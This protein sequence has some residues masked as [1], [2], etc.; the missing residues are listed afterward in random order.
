MANC[1]SQQLSSSSSSSKAR[2]S[3]RLSVRNSI[4][5]TPG[6]A[7]Q[8]SVRRASNRIDPNLDFPDLDLVDWG[9]F[10]EDSDDDAAQN[11]TNVAHEGFGNHN[12]ATGQTPNVV[13]TGHAPIKFY[14][15]PNV[16]VPG[17]PHVSFPPANR[18][19]GP[20]VGLPMGF[21]QEKAPFVI[22]GKTV[23]LSQEQVDALSAVAGLAPQPLLTDGKR[24]SVPKSPGIRKRNS[25]F[26]PQAAYSDPFAGSEHIDPQDLQFGVFSNI[27][28]TP[29]PEPTAYPEGYADARQLL[30]QSPYYQS[31][32][33]QGAPSPGGRHIQFPQPE[34]EYLQ[35]TIPQQVS[36][37]VYFERDLIPDLDF[38]EPNA[39]QYQNRGRQSAYPS[40]NSSLGYGRRNLP[41]ESKKSARQ[42]KARASVLGRETSQQYQK[43]KLATYNSDVRINRTTKGL[44]TRTA[45]INNYDPRN[46]YTYMPHPLGTLEQPW[47]APWKAQGSPYLHE[48][49]D[50]SLKEQDGGEEIAIYELK[51][52]E[53]NPDEIQDFILGYPYHRNKLTLRLQVTP[54]DSGRRYR[55]GADK[56]RFKDCPNRVS[57]VPATIK[58]GWFR[59]AFDERD[60]DEYDP[61]A[62][63]CGFVHL[64]CMERFLDFEY[65]C[66]KAHVVV[67]FRVQMRNEP[68]GT[69]AAAFTTKNR[70]AG[71]L[72]EQFIVHA[73]N[74][75]RQLGDN[76]G[77]RQMREFQNYPVNMPYNGQIWDPDYN[78]EDTLSYHMFLVTEQDRPAA[79]MAQFQGLSPTVLSVHRGDLGMVAEANARQKQA[80]KMSKGGNKKKG[81]NASPV[82]DKYDGNSSFDIEVRRRIQ[83]AKE[84]L[85]RR[86]QEPKTRVP[87]E[88]D[89]GLADIDG[90]EEEEE[91]AATQYDRQPWD[92]PDDASDIEE[93]H[94][95]RQGTRR[96]GRNKGKQPVYSDEPDIGPAYKPQPQRPLKRNFQE[97]EQSQKN[98]D[99]YVYGQDQQYLQNS[100]AQNGFAQ[101]YMDGPAP[102]RKRSSIAPPQGYARAH[103]Y[104]PN[105]LQP[106]Q[107]WQEND[108]DYEL[109]EADLFGDLN[110]PASPKRKRPFTSSR[111][112][113]QQ[114]HSAQYRT[115]RFSDLVGSA[116]SPSSSIMRHPGSRTPSG[117]KR[118]ASFNNQP[119]SQQKTFHSDAPPHEMPRMVKELELDINTTSPR[120]AKPDVSSGRT[121]RSGRSLSGLSSISPESVRAMRRSCGG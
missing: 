25:Q 6:R 44:T 118:N 74:A 106:P 24:T 8:A 77:V 29:F 87:K 60:D 102:K 49:R 57:G 14:H 91:V 117:S 52:R 19:M 105:L 72:A 53:M 43:P 88:T 114:Q 89:H 31:T 78:F 121:L 110:L 85:N 26:R 76:Y 56:C 69:F 38:D 2:R 7:R 20:P 80:K 54:G 42:D 45:K 81:K 58:H 36:G 103:S 5:G 12:Y 16:A 62:A 3:T 82:T 30:P 33:W 23:M 99:Q 17:T 34:P 37:P 120:G 71:L 84:V 48:Y 41:V 109:D 65:I 50:S 51:N 96:S 79:Q 21:K 112:D 113:E 83:R 97:Y 111:P 90:E 63:N 95:F 22:N 75:S 92:L 104:R 108:Y 13:P 39:N 107:Q 86:A 98:H 1:S 70:V 93:G 47:G 67:D 10:A 101:G 18:Q 61:F 68:K 116:P 32:Q 119:V 115:K 40:R 35:L 59:I 9:E 66:R 4:V 11:R 100:Y 73:G 28:Y 94:T 64:Y 15:N 46:F 27:N 55:Q